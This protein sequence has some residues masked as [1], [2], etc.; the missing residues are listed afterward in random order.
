M[1]CSLGQCDDSDESIN[2][3]FAR[4]ICWI[5]AWAIAL[6]CLAVYLIFW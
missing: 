6:V 2:A 3:E 4:A 5:C 1:K